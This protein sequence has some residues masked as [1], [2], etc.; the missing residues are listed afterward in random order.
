MF[1]VYCAKIDAANVNGQRYNKRS[2]RLLTIIITVVSPL[3]LLLLLLLR[4]L[5]LLRYWNS[6]ACC[7]TKCSAYFVQNC[8]ILFKNCFKDSE[9]VAPWDNKPMLLYRMQFLAH[10]AYK[11]KMLIYVLLRRHIDTF[12]KYMVHNRQVLLKAKYYPRVAPA[13]SVWVRGVELAL[14]VSWPDGV[15]GAYTRLLVLYWYS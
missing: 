9:I 11:P 1:R 2:I 4:V 7:S 10:S 13:A 15:R 12:Y 6:T 5:L 8:T 14:S 3:L